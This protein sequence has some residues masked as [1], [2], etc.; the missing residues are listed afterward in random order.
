MTAEADVL[1]L[2]VRQV[3]VLSSN[4]TVGYLARPNFRSWPVSAI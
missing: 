3:S 2:A 4:S 1:P